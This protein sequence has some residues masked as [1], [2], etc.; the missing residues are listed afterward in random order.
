MKNL[1]IAGALAFA[2]FASPVAAQEECLKLADVQA[3]L[4]A[5]SNP[6]KMVP[7]DELAQFLEGIAP[8]LG[9]IPDGTTA[10]IVAM[11]GETAVF[12]LEI[13]G[14]MTPPIVFPSEV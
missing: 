3:M 7:A 5:E 8:V 2:L 13:N 9:G 11:L 4:D 10:A 12:G 14:C 1:L 6:H